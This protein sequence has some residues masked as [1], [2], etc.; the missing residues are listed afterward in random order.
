MTHTQDKSGNHAA[1]TAPI[2]DA[3]LWARLEEMKLD[4]PGASLTFAA[5]LARENGWTMQHT[6]DVITEY[7][8]FLYL[9][10]R[11]GHPVTPSDAVDQAWH[12]H[13]VYTRH[14]WGVL[15]KD[16]LGFE[17]HH[18]P[19][20]GGEHEQAKFSDWY[21]RTLDSY[22]DV[23]GEP[24]ADVWPEGAERFDVH[25][26]MQ[27]VDVAASWVVPKPS[28]RGLGP[29]LMYL[30][31]GLVA[32]LIV[33]GLLFDRSVAASQGGALGDS[34]TVQ[35]VIFVAL[36]LALV[37]F[38]SGHARW[39]L[40]LLGAG[41]LL[42]VAVTSPRA[43]VF[44]FIVGVIGIALLMQGARKNGK[45]GGGCAAGGGCGGGDGGGGGCGGGCGGGGG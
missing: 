1:A 21:Q 10:A 29:G 22:R 38:H 8:R 44:L 26:R 39:V 35:T 37:A 40:G 45:D 11:A 15:C 6:H 12:L 31:A 2:F 28:L 42:A 14:Y 19:T 36:L 43:L 18:G 20:L 17:L 23:F 7:R 9:A 41:G 3:G 32:L 16:V 34:G 5:R 33:F 25:R 4:A 24:P 13:L 30:S 27:R